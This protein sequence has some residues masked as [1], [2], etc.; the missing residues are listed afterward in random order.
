MST[1][2]MAE[3]SEKYK[4][5]MVPAM[6][7]KVAG[8]EVAENSGYQVESVEVVLSREAASA[9][10][11]RL[12]N[13][14]DLKNRCF[15]SQVSAGFILGEL[16]EVEMGYGSSLTPLFYGYI[17]EISYELGEVPAVSVIAV[18]VRKLM[19]GSKKSIISHSV[20]SYSDAF[21][22]VI[23]KYQAAYKSVSVDATDR[24]D[25]ECIIQNGGDYAFI[26]E[27][28][29]RKAERD[30]FVHAGK[31]YFKKPST[32]LFQTV[33][34]TWPGD[35]FSF[36]RR[37]SFH[38]M[39]IRIMGQDMK[40]KEAVEASVSVKADDRQRSLASNEV[41]ELDAD[42]EDSGEARKIAAYQAQQEKRRARQ[43]SGSCIGLPEI[44]PGGHVRIT[45]G[46]KRYIDGTYDVIEAKHTF[47][48]NGYR[49]SFETGGWKR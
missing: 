49:T 9:A 41:T 29:C 28:L 23:R 46:D 8:L 22:E 12:T 20:R 27:E 38:D 40:K 39:V 18:D 35:L 42:V 25:V 11:I 44:L 24:M 48:S 10:T 15:H 1:V 31:V 5:F 36:Q 19:M 34:L 45:N 37:S 3:L 21:C 4:H 47:G 33:Q 13:V 43:A 14:Y 26:S 2:S 32:G 17:D 7:L 6:K 16:I 30:F